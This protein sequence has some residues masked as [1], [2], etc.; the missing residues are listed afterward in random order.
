MASIVE[1]IAGDKRLELGNEEFARA[2][3]MGANWTHLRIG[4]RVAF[5]G[6]ANITAAEFVVGLCQGTSNTYRSGSTTAFIGLGLGHNGTSWPQ[7]FAFTSGPPA[8]YSSAAGATALT[9]V[10]STTTPT[11]I[12]TSATSQLVTAAPATV[13]SVVMAEFIKSGTTYTMRW[14]APSTAG[15]AQADV[16][17]ASLLFDMDAE[18]AV[19]ARTTLFASGAVTSSGSLDTVSIS[20][21]KASPTVE[22]SDVNVVRFS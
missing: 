10:G 20:W 7:D 17:L 14:L 5:N 2:M 15:Q 21:N 9:R 6:S 13:R 18:P 11:Y 3:A 8:Y 19:A 1:T 12:N 22:I 4:M 16:A